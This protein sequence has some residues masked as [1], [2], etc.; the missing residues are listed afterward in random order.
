VVQGTLAVSLVDARRKQ[1]VWSGT[2]KAKID[3][4]KQGKLYDQVD[5]AITE[6]FKNYPPAK[7]K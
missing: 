6:M 4:E 2:A 1:T 7:E 3:Q 5:K